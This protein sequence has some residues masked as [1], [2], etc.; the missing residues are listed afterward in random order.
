MPWGQKFVLVAMFQ[1]FEKYANEEQNTETD[2]PNFQVGFLD[3]LQTD[4]HKEDN[5]SQELHN[6][7]AGER[8]SNTVKKTT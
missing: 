1:N 6:F 4:K 3:F 7:I 5:L 8:S 2:N